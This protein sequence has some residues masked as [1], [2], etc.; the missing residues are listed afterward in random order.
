MKPNNILVASRS[1]LTIKLAD[2]GLPQRIMAKYHTWQAPEEVQKGI[3]TKAS[4]VW[5]LGVV[6]A[7]L[8]EILPSMTVDDERSKEWHDHIIS[9]IGCVYDDMSRKDTDK[10][11]SRRTLAD[12]LVETLHDHLLLFKPKSRSNSKELYNGSVAQ[13]EQEIESLSNAGSEG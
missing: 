1:P 12:S 13:I 10:Q 6:L 4:D 5:S 2:Y 9:E 3:Q 7:S 11:D 8:L